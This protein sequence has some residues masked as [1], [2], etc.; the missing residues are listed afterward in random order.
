MVYSIEGRERI[1]NAIQA[2]DALRTGIPFNDGDR[3]TFAV[4]LKAGENTITSSQT[5]DR[6]YH[7]TLVCK[8]TIAN[9]SPLGHGDVTQSIQ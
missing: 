9:T 8:D 3:I 1:L 6:V 4:T 2:N 7:V 5:T